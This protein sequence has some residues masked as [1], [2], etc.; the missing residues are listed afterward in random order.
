VTSSR[1]FGNGGFSPTRTRT[2]APVSALVENPATPAATA[3][4]P[5]NRYQPGSSTA[6]TTTTTTS[7]AEVSS[8]RYNRFGSNRAKATS[9]TTSTT[10]NTPSERPS[11][12]RKSP[13][14]RRPVFISREVNEPVSVVSKR[15]FNYSG[16]RLKLPARPTARTTSTTES[17]EEEEPLD[18]EEEEEEH[19]G[20]DEQY[21][22]ESDEGTEEHSESS[23]LEKLPLQEEAVTPV[24]VTKNEAFAHVEPSEP[25]TSSEIDNESST[26]ST[27]ESQTDV[28]E[29]TNGDAEVSNDENDVTTLHPAHEEEIV[30]EPTTIIPQENQSTEDAHVDEQTVTTEQPLDSTSKTEETENVSKPEETKTSKQEEQST[31]K[32]ENQSLNKQEEQS[33]SQYDDEGEGEDYEYDDE[34]GSEDSTSEVE[35]Q[36]SKP[37]TPSAEHKDDREIISVVTTKSVVNGS[38]ILPVPVTPS[39]NF[40]TEEEVESSHADLKLETTTSMTLDEEKGPNATENYVVVASIQPSRSINGARFLPFPAIEQEET[41]QTLSELERKV[42]SKQQQTPAQ[43]QSE[44]SEE[45]QASSS[46]QPP[47]VSSTESIIDKLDRLACHWSVEWG[48][49]WPSS[50]G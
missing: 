6:S 20:S 49:S 48:S 35:N 22:E 9:T 18:D 4:R 10:Q 15:P 23:S 1:P 28:S 16:A 31:S 44:G 37:S 45:V 27:E 30:D 26:S 43:K 17:V 29:V 24:T 47:V 39:T 5:R 7:S 38:T 12:G 25:T 2:Q 41:K 8:K 36:D 3:F 11:F 32:S 14:P 21:E 42:H 34:E 40:V 50:D 46:I 13:N 33:E 19:E